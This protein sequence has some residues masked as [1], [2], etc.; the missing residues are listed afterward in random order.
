[1]MNKYGGDGQNDKSDNA[2]T[3]AVW[4]DIDQAAL[5]KHRHADNGFVEDSSGA[6]IVHGMGHQLQAGRI[7]CNLSIEDV[8]RQLRLSPKQIEA[9]EKE[10]FE[11]LPS[12]TFLR[13]FIRNY[14]NLVKLDPK[15]MLQLL[16]P[17][18]A[19]TTHATLN[20]A[21][22]P[23]ATS[24]SSDWAWNRQNYRN[25]RKQGEPFKLVLL[26]LFL[27][28]I[29]GIYSSVDWK[30]LPL[31]N[32]GTET[33]TDHSAAT[34]RMKGQSGIELQ[35]PISAPVPIDTKDNVLPLIQAENA[36]AQLKQKPTSSVD[37]LSAA[38]SSAE[39]TSSDQGTLRFKF[40]SDSWVEV[41]DRMNKVVFK[42]A[43][44]ADTEQV[45]SGKRPL[46]LV[47]GNAK[48]VNL[49]YNERE[50]DLIPYTNKSSGIARLT[51]E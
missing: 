6:S 36:D 49:S 12:G 25:G 5:I 27:L 8:S 39:S 22:P 31:I 10:D 16:P 14:A 32:D 38:N 13:G 26:I 11:K 34:E 29:Y 45:V 24:Y 47:V 17:P 2:K 9:I 20:P 35:L 1:M 37:S 44:V 42:Q 19:A 21:Y 3:E 23:R 51:L 7:A 48:Y 41:R 50:V 40:A 18:S 15:P 33:D 43:N 30:Q 46:T 4:V 28:V